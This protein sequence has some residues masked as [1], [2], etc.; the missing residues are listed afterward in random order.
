MVFD[1]QKASLLKRASAYLLDII[2]L[3]ILATGF[4]ALLSLATGFDKQSQRFDDKFTQYTTQFETTYGI[5]FD[6]TQAEQDALSEEDK[7]NWIENKA[8]FTANTLEADQD[9]VSLKIMLDN[10]ILLMISVAALS[11]Y[12]VLEFFIPLWLGNGQTVGKKVFGVALMRVDGVKLSTFSLFVRTVLGK[13]TVGTMVPVILLFFISGPVGLGVT[14][15]M[16]LLQLGLLFFSHNH[17]TIHDAY[18]QTVAIDLASQMIFD[19][20]EDLLA[21]KEKV[22]KEMAEKKEY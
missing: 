12:L 21:Y 16:L 17:T 13:Y 5:P 1:I 20:P 19:T 10:L 3:V 8:F 7:Q 9:L 15:L 4:A 14:I 6:L 11:S 2:L 22:A 18:A